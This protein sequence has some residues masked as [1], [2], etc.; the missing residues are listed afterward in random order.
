M[1]WKII[2]RRINSD[3]DMHYSW[4]PCS[5][6]DMHYAKSRRKTTESF[7]MEYTQNDRALTQLLLKE[8]LGNTAPTL[9]SKTVSGTTQ[10]QG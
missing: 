9:T 4:T 6:R 1:K 3:R 7:S 10:A 2:C 8:A 5:D